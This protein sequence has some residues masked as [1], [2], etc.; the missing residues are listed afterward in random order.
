[1]IFCVVGGGLCIAVGFDLLW[2]RRNT[3]AVRF[4]VAV[5]FWFCGFCV[6]SGGLVD[7]VLVLG[8]LGFEFLWL[9]WCSLCLA[10]RVSGSVVGGARFCLRL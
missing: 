2:A 8:L 10:F 3:A 9:L 5:G 7:C 6:F 4:G 1:M